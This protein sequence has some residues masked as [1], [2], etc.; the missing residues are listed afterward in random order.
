MPPVVGRFFIVF[1]FRSLPLVIIPISISL[2]PGVDAPFTLLSGGVETCALVSQN[3]SRHSM[4]FFWLFLQIGISWC[5]GWLFFGVVFF[6]ASNMWKK[7]EMSIHR[8]V[9]ICSQ[10]SQ[11][12]VQKMKAEKQN[13]QIVATLRWSVDCTG[14]CY[15]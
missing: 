9:A 8:R 2:I 3:L 7:G 11:S 13:R 10:F 5:F 1:V 14:H 15:R 12:V 4:D 6:F